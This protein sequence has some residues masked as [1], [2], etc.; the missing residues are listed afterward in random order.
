MTFGELT[1][2]EPDGHGKWLCR[3]S[4]G[5]LRHIGSYALKNVRK[6]CGCKKEYYRIKNNTRKR[7][8]NYKRLYTI[9]NNMNDRCY[10]VSSISYRRYGAKGVTVC[11]EWRRSFYEFQKWAI[12]NGYA[13]D[14]SIDRIDNSLG[15]SSDNCRW[16][17]LIEQ[18]NNKSSNK[19]IDLDGESHTIAEWSRIS[20][21]KQGTIYDRLFIRGWNAKDAI[22][23]RTGIDPDRINQNT[24]YRFLTND[25][26]VY[27]SEN[28]ETTS[29]K[30]L[31]KLL[32][33]SR[34]TVN[35]Y[36]YYQIK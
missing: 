23:G 33:I 3:C 8:P 25:E 34:K 5:N 26:K 29:V 19:H 20:G 30:D 15:Y 13:K 18:A 21:T 9:W 36:R 14:L 7:N 35:R 6:S 17:T 22:Y 24:K 32:N 16:A 11:D 10:D 4:C 28:Y 2:L 12:Q 27:I 1:V 31:M